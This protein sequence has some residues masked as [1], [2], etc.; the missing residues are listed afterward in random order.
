MV[1]KMLQL[2]QTRR[3]DC[4]QILSDSIVQKRIDFSKKVTVS[5][6][7]DLIDTIKVP[8]NIKDI[9]LKL[10]KIKHY[11]DNDI[12]YQNITK[13]DQFTKP[14]MIDA[15]RS[16]TPP[17]NKEKDFYIVKTNKGNNICFNKEDETRYMQ[18][19]LLNDNPLNNIINKPKNNIIKVKK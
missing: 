6:K 18:K 11:E 3:P 13:S 15:M 7:A 2:E 16:K 14:K 10:P 19:K 12:K 1:N 4:D 5:E 9:N 17:I 8:N